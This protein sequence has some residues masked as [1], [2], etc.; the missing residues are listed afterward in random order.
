ME[1]EG[2]LPYSQV[3]ATCSSPEPHRF[4]PCFPIPLLEVCFNIILQSTPGSQYREILYLNI[5]TRSVFVMEMECVLSNVGSRPTF[6]K[7]NLYE[8]KML[9]NRYGSDGPRIK[10]REGEIFRNLPDRPWGPPSLLY[11]GY[12]VFP[13]VK[14]P[15]RGIDHPP[16]LATRLKKE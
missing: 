4:S 10:S 5:I 8:L 9:G 15:G 16:H 7:Y 3:H 2:S 11:K 6:V 1:P 13:G 14:R 12:Q